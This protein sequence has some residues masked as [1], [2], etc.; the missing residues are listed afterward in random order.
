MSSFFASLLEGLIAVYI[1]S[2]QIRCRL[3]EFRN[4]NTG[5]LLLGEVKKKRLGLVRTRNTVL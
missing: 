3:S 1:A 2:I 5:I 4:W